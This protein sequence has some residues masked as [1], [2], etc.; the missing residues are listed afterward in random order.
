M[1]GSVV[2][3]CKDHC[4]VY[5]SG[6]AKAKKATLEDK[7]DVLSRIVK[8]GFANIKRFSWSELARET[9][10]VYVRSQKL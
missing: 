7:I 6:M 10:K 2:S 4:V 1:S 9:L 5:N 8:K 3:I